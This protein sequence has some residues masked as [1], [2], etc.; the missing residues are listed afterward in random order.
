[1][2]TTGPDSDTGIPAWL[3]RLGI[4][5]IT[6]LHVHFMPASVQRKVWAYFD[7]VGESGGPPWRVTYRHADE[8][9]VEILRDLGVRAFTTLNYAHRPGMAQWLNEY[10]ADFADAHLEAIRSGTFFPE[11]EAPAV[12]RDALDDGVRIFKIHIQVGGFS[13][14]DPQLDEA[15]QLVSAA[16]TPVVIH[17]GNGPR[18]GEHTG[19]GPVRELMRRFPQLVLI[20]AHAGLPE[21]R[22]FAE[23]AAEHPAVHLDTTMVGTDF[24]EAFAPVPPEYP[25]LLAQLPGKVVLG[26]DFPTIPYPYS[27]QLDVLARWGLGEDWLRDVLWR[28]P[29]RLVGLPTQAGEMP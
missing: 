12:V 3:E 11:P 19:I 9:R 4:P 8:R 10:S 28:T 2:P 26:T 17:C 18:P 14:L 6:D 23:L 15:W 20:I 5:G 24:T 1:M 13:P 29:R 16:R 22:E 21:Y 25:E 27:H 7:R